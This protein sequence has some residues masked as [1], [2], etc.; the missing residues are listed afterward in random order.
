MNLSFGLFGGHS[1]EK[2]LAF[3]R[4][5]EKAGMQAC[6]IFEDYFYGGAFTTATACAMSTTK[7]Q[8]GIGVINPFT[9]HPALSA[10]E[11]AALDALSNGRLILG[12]GASNKRW[13]EDQSGI[14]FEKPIQAVSEAVEI[15]KRL[16]SEGQVQF[17]G[18]VFHTGHI[19][20]EFETHRKDMPV[21]MGVKGPKALFKA[22]QIADGVI[23]SSL[24]SENYIRYAK[25]HIVEGAKSVGRDPAA[26][27]IA[28]YFPTCVNEDAAAAKDAVRPYLAKF[29]GVHGSHPIMT[30]AGLTEEIIAPFRAAFLAGK[31]ESVISLVT[32][33]LVDTLAIAGSPSQCRKKLELVCQAGVDMPIAF[34]LPGHDPLETI[35]SLEKYLLRS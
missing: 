19:H 4:R 3:T 29:I 13:I 22:G 1:L 31:P 35:D 6:W 33:E 16:I 17:D 26:L 28:A 24:S 25:E 8:I 20:L 11:A 27:K 9:R 10:M 30:E 32:D 12:M 34:E 18:E 5:I 23:L 14:P 7:L 21:Y 2:T 15:I